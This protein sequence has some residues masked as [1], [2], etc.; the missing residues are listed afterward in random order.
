M[1]NLIA[2]QILFAWCGSVT[3][4]AASVV[5]RV[6]QATPSMVL[7][8]SPAEDFRGPRLQFPPTPTLPRHDENVL[9][10]QLHGLRPDTRYHYRLRNPETSS[11]RLG[12]FTT[13][14]PRGEAVSFTFAFASCA[15]TGSNHP[16]FDTILDQSP[17]FFLHAG[18]LHYEDIDTNEPD[19]FRQAYLQSLSAPSQ[20]RLYRETPVFYLWDD[21]DFGPNNSDRTS[22]ARPAAHL[23]YRENVPHFPL[24]NAFNDGPITQTFSVGRVLFILL[25]LR[26]DRDPP[27][28][29]ADNSPP[30]MLGSW[31]KQWLKNEL[32]N[33]RD[34]H[35]LIF[36][37]S[38]V[39]WIGESTP[40][41]DNWGR[42]PEERTE[43]SDWMVENRITGVCFLSGDA[44]M[45]AADD[46]RHNRYTSDGQGPG[47]PVLQAGSLDRRGSIKGGPYSVPPVLPAPGEGQFGLVQV[48]DRGDS[49]H[50]L[51]RGLNHEGTEKLRLKF[52]VG[53]HD[54]SL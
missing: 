2:L 34:H 4:N 51:F 29:N 18:D 27:K 35:P 22:P 46:G 53:G 47:F 39:P 16:V 48:I 50:V 25:D 44:H 23:T 40:W 17:L 28:P 9:R 20:A 49:L 5:I 37:L 54:F 11:P 7:E 6:A 31:Q 32:L 26:S 13:L 3:D 38:G 8:V 41:G 15:E 43:L 45:L 10:F 12:G 1:V 36:I 24:A 19:R 42:Y 52:D 30:S 21:H 33:A 14:P